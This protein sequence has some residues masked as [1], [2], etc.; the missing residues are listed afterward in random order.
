MA[1]MMAQFHGNLQEDENQPDQAIRTET[2]QRILHRITKRAPVEHSQ[3]MSELLTDD[4][5]EEALRLSANHKAP[6]LNGIPY[7]VWKIL[8][9]RY[10]D[11]I[12]HKRP[13]FN[14]IKTLRRVYNDIERYG[15]AENSKFS[16]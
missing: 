1:N 11:A 5:V 14:I 6:G 2:I 7:E 10:K 4:D 9:A 12:A 13:A 3:R 8:H 15:L 16:E